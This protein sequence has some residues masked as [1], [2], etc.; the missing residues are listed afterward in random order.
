MLKRSLTNQRCPCAFK[1]EAACLVLITIAVIFS[2]IS[3]FSRDSGAFRTHTGASYSR[4]DCHGW[5]GA[6]DWH[7]R[8]LETY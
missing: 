6:G 4:R 1:N 3:R 2:S 8:D 7:G 5:H